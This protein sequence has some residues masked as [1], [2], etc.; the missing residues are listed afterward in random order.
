MRDASAGDDPRMDVDT[1]RRCPCCELR[2]AN[3][4]ELDDHLRTDHTTLGSDDAPGPPPVVAGTVAVPMGSVA[5]G[6]AHAARCPVLVVP[7]GA[8]ARALARSGAAPARSAT[9]VRLRG[10]PMG[11]PS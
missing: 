3:R 8:T 11:Q 6:L 5:R 2:F 1:V 9:H 7:P 10:A 4:N